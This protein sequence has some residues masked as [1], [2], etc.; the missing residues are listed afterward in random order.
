MKPKRSLASVVL[1]LV[2]VLLVT[3]LVLRGGYGLP[4]LVEGSRFWQLKRR[5]SG[6][7]LPARTTGEQRESTH[8]AVRKP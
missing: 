8:E 2:A 5:G 1:E 4:K 7:Q 3:V 6:E